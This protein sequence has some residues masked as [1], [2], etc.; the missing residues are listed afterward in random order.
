[1]KS[2][3][4]YF[5]SLTD[6][7]IEKNIEII[8]SFIELFPEPR[9]SKVKKMLDGDLGEKFFLSPASSRRSFHN[10]FPGGLAKHSINVVKNALAISKQLCPNRW[11]VHKIAFC[12]LFH[13]LYKA[14]SYKAT[15]EEWKFKRG[16]FYDVLNDERMQSGFG[17][18]FLLQKYGIELDYEETIAIQLTDGPQQFHQFKEPAF[19]FIICWADQWAMV[20]EKESDL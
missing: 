3:D 15:N 18:L 6:K 9:K 2:N 7:D 10:A 4:E 20:E 8:N 5:N 13:D 14:V 19:S 16:D 17:S 11:P 1:M 12:A